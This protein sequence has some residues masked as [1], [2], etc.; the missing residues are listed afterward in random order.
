[1]PMS[2]TKLAILI[3]SLSVIASASAK[4]TSVILVAQDNDVVAEYDATTG[5]VINASLVSGLNNPN[6]LAV[7]ADNAILVSSVGTAGA[8]V[9]AKYDLTTGAAINANFVTGLRYPEGIFVD[10]NNNLY[11][12]NSGRTSGSDAGNCV[13]KYNASTGATINTQLVGTYVASATYVDSQN[14]LYS[15]G[16]NGIGEYNATSGAVVNANF[17]TDAGVSQFAAYGN[18]LFATNTNQH[19]IFEFNLLTGTL[20]NPDF[21]T[22]ASNSFLTGL[23]TDASGHLFIADDANHLIGEY[24]ATTG[25]AINADFI[26]DPGGP[27]Q[28]VITNVSVPEPSTLCLLALGSAGLLAWRRHV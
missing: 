16:Y 28:I 14:N 11:V 4:A 7:S 22:L 13:G 26:P 15:A 8:G 23:A 19:C 5:A 25:A 17:S 27:E 12:S 1:M 3:A 10:S 21:I 9:V 2:K 6:G 24:D 18:D 20:I